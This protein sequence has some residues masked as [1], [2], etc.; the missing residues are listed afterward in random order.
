VSIFALC[1]GDAA[2]VARLLA[3]PDGADA[4][5]RSRPQDAPAAMRPAPR[6]A[7]PAAPEFFGDAQ[8]RDAW[9]AA[10][11]ALRATGANL[12]PIDFEPFAA[13]AA[14]LYQGPWVIERRFAL[15]GLPRD[16]TIDPVVRSIIQGGADPGAEQAFEAE[17]RR[18]GLQQR[19]HAALSGFDALA[20]PT[21][22]THYRLED[23]AREPVAANSRL[24]T[25]TNFANLADL[26]ALALPGP[27]RAD[28]LPAGVTL[29]ARPWHDEALQ[30]FGHRWQRQSGLALGA[31]GR[32]ADLAPLPAPLDCLRLAVV[33]AHLSGLPLNGQ[34][35]DRGARPAGTARTAARY[36]LYELPRSEPRKPG[37]VR[38]AAGGAA[39]EVELWDLPL[40]SWGSFMAGVPAPLAIGSIELADG[41]WVKG[42]LCEPEAL[43]GARDISAA[44]GWRAW[45]QA[46]D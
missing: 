26:C 27:F 46:G 20:V 40:G 8:A 36:R 23:I 22:P 44:G 2:L 29:L 43:A 45:L 15:R 12:H 18:A 28:G 34:L 38:A 3:G 1:V 4:Y 17:Y 21:A 6:I 7:V 39:I 42:F 32:R 35:L 14:L 41:T 37:L 13:L 24:G 33:G 25:Y 5:A 31:T 11:T 19:I 10:L 30:D 16:A 9:D